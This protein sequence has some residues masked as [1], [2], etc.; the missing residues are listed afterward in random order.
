LYEQILVSSSA[1]KF[2]NY[3]LNFIVNLT[4]KYFIFERILFIWLNMTSI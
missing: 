1:T 2:H 4:A 3:E